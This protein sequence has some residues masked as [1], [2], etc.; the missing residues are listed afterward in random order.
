MTILDNISFGDARALAL[1]KAS[2]KNKTKIILLNEALGKVIAQD[3]ICKKNLPSFNNSAMDGFAFK[4]ENRGKKL[5]IISTIY[6]GDKPKEILKDNSCYKIMTGAKLPDDA[7]T[8]V[9]IENC[10]NITDDFVTVPKDIKKFSSVKFKGEEQTKGNILFNKGELIT[11]AHIA[12][13]ASQGIISIEVYKDLSIAIVSTGDEIKEPWE[14]ASEDEIYNANGFA[15]ISLL[16]KFNFN[17]T[18]VGSI[19]DNLE[20]TIKFINKLQSY[21]VIITTGGIS[22]GDADYLYEAF[23]QNGLKSFFHGI[24]V[25]PGRPTM[26]GMMNN[27]YIMAMPGNPLTTMLNCFVLALPIL[28][29]LQ[30]SIKYHQTFVY[31]KNQ[32]FLKLNPHRANIVLGILEN[33]CFKA[34][35]NNKYGSGMITPMYESNCIAIFSYGINQVEVNETVKIILIES[36]ALDLNDNNI[37]QET[38]K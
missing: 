33:G 3:I 15:L 30:G 1:K 26:M 31:A 13:L 25:K 19:P 35:R 6:A 24:K 21:D 32:K 34:T 16:K 18:Y 2:P 8:I 11:P 23:Q 36:L 38:L 37:N 17:P 9:P 20:Q 7:N 14:I 5:K 27:S 10:I 28:F 29:K 12:M 22:M 4:Y